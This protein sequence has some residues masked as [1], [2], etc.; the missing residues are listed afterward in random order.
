MH[1]SCARGDLENVISDIE[2]GININIIASGSIG[3]PLCVACE[4]GNYDIVMFLLSNKPKPNVHLCT[5][6]ER[7][8]AIHKA[9]FGNSPDI[10]DLLLKHDAN[11]HVTDMVRNKLSNNFPINFKFNH[12]E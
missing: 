9:A 2:F 8:T 11:L 1:Q 4:N 7:A 5:K 10:I 6:A 12:L 3:T